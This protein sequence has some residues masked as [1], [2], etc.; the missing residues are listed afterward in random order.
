VPLVPGSVPW[1]TVLVTAGLLAVKAIVT[2]FW[3]IEMLNA[4]PGAW[5]DLRPLIAWGILLCVTAPSGIWAL[6]LGATLLVVRSGT[7]H[8]PGGE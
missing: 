1:A 7:R 3:A 4:P 8:N 6:V 5:L 2:C